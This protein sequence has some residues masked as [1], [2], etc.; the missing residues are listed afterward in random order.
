MPDELSE[1]EYEIESVEEMRRP[2]G[3]KPMEFLV[4]WA[5]HPLD[6][7]EPSSWLKRSQF[8]T[9][10]GWDLLL[11]FERRRKQEE[12]AEAEAK[13]M[14]AKKTRKRPQSAPPFKELATVCHWDQTGIA[15]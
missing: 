10:G 8:T 7:N 4:K 1:D 3:S 11:A 14:A 6:R 5:G 13:K 15:W 12:A 2:G 9:T